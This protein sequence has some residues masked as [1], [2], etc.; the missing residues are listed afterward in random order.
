MGL[1]P[2]HLIPRF[3]QWE[4]LRKKD[5]VVTTVLDFSKNRVKKS[6]DYFTICSAN[7]KVSKCGKYLKKRMIVL[8]PFITLVNLFSLT[9]VFN[10]SCL[11][12]LPTLENTHKNV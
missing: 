9:R 10:I 8:S 11:I 6:L 4:C 12:L 1:D 7:L 3:I 2:E 5:D